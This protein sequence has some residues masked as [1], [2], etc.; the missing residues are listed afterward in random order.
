MTLCD[1][2]NTHSVDMKQG[3]RFWYVQTILHFY[4]FKKKKKTLLKNKYNLLYNNFFYIIENVNV[5]S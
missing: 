1:K 3:V 2:N 4:C 5:A